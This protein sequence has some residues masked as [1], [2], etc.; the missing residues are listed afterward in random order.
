MTKMLWI[1]LGGAVGSVLRYLV[2][3][4]GAR[5]DSAPMLA[6]TLIVN[7][8][9]CL[10]IGVVAGGLG[11][12][13]W[14]RDEHRLA[15]MVGLLG[16]FTTF[17]TYGLEAMTMV[18]AGHRWSAMSHVLAHNGLGLAMVWVGYRVGVR[19]FGV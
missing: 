12:T 9:G 3:G 7:V 16:G 15:V 19:A 1:G 8:V 4:W 10:V 14:M 5:F 17:S 18:D 2:S 13:S 6:G 11:E